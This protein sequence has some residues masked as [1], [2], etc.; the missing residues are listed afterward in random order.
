MT[1]KTFNRLTIQQQQKALLKAFPN[2][3]LKRGQA[4]QNWEKNQSARFNSET[5]EM[6]R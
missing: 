3:L 2:D 6:V 5:C 1:I 4:R